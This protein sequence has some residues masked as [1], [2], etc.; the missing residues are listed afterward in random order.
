MEQKP[1]YIL[2][3][4]L[5]L[6][7]ALA[8][9]SCSSSE[10]QEDGVELSSDELPMVNADTDMLPNSLEQS[11]DSLADSAGDLPPE[12][13]TDV[14]GVDGETTALAD[15]V[16]ATETG[17][18][19]EAPP[20]M[21][22]VAPPVASND[23]YSGDSYTAESSSGGGSHTYE[24]QKGD[25]LMKI[26]YRCYGD[27]YQWKKVLEDNQDRIPN[28]NS[29]VAGTQLKVDQAPQEDDFGGYERYLIQ[30]G[31]TLGS[32]SDGVYGTTAK[33]KHLWKL[34]DRMIKDPNRI[35]AGFFLKYSM[36]QEEQMESERL[37]QMKAPAPLAGNAPSPESVR[38]PS[39][40]EA[41]A[42]GV[43]PA[44]QQQ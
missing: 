35:Y 26:A 23:S 2:A 43:M 31:D 8:F 42:A 13:S 30:N 5:A 11:G 12:A 27:L 6:T 19:T 37:K 7:A 16:A 41:S 36:T 17:P 22:E 20:S 33:W 3:F 10:V 21:N 28:P 44:P 38:G 4:T 29:L 1:K 39:S 15:A 18:A 25:T 14:P 34:N 9:S 32:I 24:V 40:Q